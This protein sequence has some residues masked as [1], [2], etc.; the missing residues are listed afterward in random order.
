[1]LIFGVMWL[2]L[3]AAELAIAYQFMKA[4]VRHH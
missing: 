1:M 4:R 3:L 2:I